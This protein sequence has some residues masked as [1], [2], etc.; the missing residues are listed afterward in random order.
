MNLSQLCKLQCMSVLHGCSLMLTSWYT[1]A[2]LLFVQMLGKWVSSLHA[3]P[4]PSFCRKLPREM[5]LMNAK[6]QS[7]HNAHR[8]PSCS[9]RLCFCH[10]RPVIQLL[11]LQMLF[12]QLHKRLRLG[13]AALQLFLGAFT[14]GQAGHLSGALTLL[15]VAA[16]SGQELQGDL[17]GVG[18]RGAGG[19]GHAE[20]PA[21]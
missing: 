7:S 9:Q 17:W 10:V 16:A 3:M 6:M 21:P 18:P 15:N 19:A 13:N 20:A 14:Q 12:S 2:V 8:R 1:N 4:L 5:Q 11:S